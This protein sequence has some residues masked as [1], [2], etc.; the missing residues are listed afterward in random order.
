MMIAR[1]ILDLAPDAR[2]YDVPLL[3]RR[4]AHVPVFLS[5][6]HAAYEAILSYIDY[7]RA[8]YPADPQYK[9]PWI[10]VNAWAI[11][12][13][14][15]ETPLGDYTQ[16]AHAP[17]SA[18]LD[19]HPFI[20]DVRSG[21]ILQRNFDVIFAAGN[22]GEF[23]FSIR[24]GK[25]DRGPGHSIWGANALPEVITVGAVRTDEMWTG[26]S[27]QGPGPGTTSNKLAHDKPDLCA[28]SN[29]CETLDAHVWNSGTSAAC[30]LT[31]GVVAALRS[32]AAWNQVNRSPAQMLA[33]LTT[34]ARKTQGPYWN[35]RLGNGIL[36]VGGAM[37][38]L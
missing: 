1:S 16:N 9:G 14:A 37:G 34:G 4:I 35:Q 18:S 12:D 10:L 7:L 25:L 6:A 26:Y 31:A 15:T 2:L 36:D 24:C 21:A 32:K 13:R 30:A 17:S 29:F 3:P 28:P 22:C 8:A 11:F 27:S 23:C 5:S 38:N 33:A 19:G 20:T